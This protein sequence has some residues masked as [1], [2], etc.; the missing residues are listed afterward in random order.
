MTPEAIE[1]AKEA[2]AVAL[3]MH[4]EDWT[5]DQLSELPLDGF[6]MY[7]L[8]A[9]MYLAVGEIMGLLSKLNSNPEGLP[10]P[11]LAFLPIIREDPVYL[12][13]WGSVL[14]RGARRVTTLATDAH[15]N[16][17]WQ[18]L[19]DGERID[20]FRRLMQAFSNHLLVRPDDQG[21]FTDR[22]LKDALRAARLYGVFEHLG[23]AEG[24][25]YHAT[26]GDAV[27]EMG[28]EASIAGGAELHVTM[29]TVRELGASH[30]PPR[31]LRILRAK[32]GGWDVVAEGEQDLAF[33][34]VGTGCVPG[35]GTDDAA[36]S[37]ALSRG[38]RRPCEPGGGLDLWQRGVCGQL[39][40]DRY[41]PSHRDGSATI[42]QS[43]KRT[44]AGFFK[45]DQQYSRIS[46]MSSMRVQCSSSRV[47][48]GR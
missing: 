1:A 23:Y 41:A 15:Q 21:G 3:V 27:R 17:A 29:P 34:P 14:A 31:V 12:S 8:H 36:P 33:T 20:S 7:N 40:D 9:N 28:E 47:C 30:Q 2:G 42:S 10:H 48:P 11:D 35:G 16:T 19:S 26:E 43:T 18:E 37:D 38:L 6:E 45:G 39:R 24:F 25:D 32:E 5:V 22:S 44:P 13:L 4:T 46:A